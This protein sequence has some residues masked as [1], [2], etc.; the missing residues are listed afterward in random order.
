MRALPTATA[1]ALFAAGFV[2]PRAAL[3]DDFFYS[4]DQNPLLRGFYLPLPSDSRRD[5]AATAVAAL[6][7]TNTVNAETRGAESLVVD[8]ESTTLDLAYDRAFGNGW[9]WRVS[10][11]VYHDDGG[12]LD[13]A[14]DSWHQFFGL[15]PGNRP[16]FP[17]DR[18]LYAYSGASRL[19]LAGARTNVGKLAGEAGWYALDDAAHTLSFWGGLGAPTGPVAAL[20]GDGAWDAAGWAHSA[21]RGLRWQAALE[22]GVTQPF[23]DRLFG[24]AAH[25]TTAFARAS[26][27]RT[28]GES[29]SLRAQLD[30][31]TARV[32]DTELRLL[33][34]TLQFSFGAT[35]RLGG[36]WRIEFGMA[37][38]AAVNTAPDVTFFVGIRG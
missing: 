24:G 32:Q 33:G 5:D 15:D 34:P 3:A 13:H 30:G 25:R 16:Y 29:W 19:D 7:V 27:S 10:L 12:I 20:A 26:V 31:N 21:W 38:D 9:R 35:H 22:A 1:A 11:P 28:L 36:R 17:K 18:L 37:E 23:G 4:R 2:S 14:I 6:S 8:G